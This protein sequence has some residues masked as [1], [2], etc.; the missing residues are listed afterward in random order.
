MFRGSH[1]LTMDDKGR[2]AIPT[3]YRDLL[4]DEC[5]GSVICTINLN[6]RCLWLYPLTE[7]EA[8]EQKLL[9]LSD[10]DP[11]QSRVKRLLLGNANEAEIDKN[12]RFIIPS[13][14][15]QYANLKKQLLLSGQVN[16]F[17]I[18]AQDEWDQQMENDINA[19]H[20]PDYEISERLQDLSL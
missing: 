10:M 16:K 19:M 20:A 6:Q 7:W 8:I 18:W 4:Q 9:K 1:L 12:G 3:R 17:E 11:Q 15:R 13:A 14:L 2:I 5:G